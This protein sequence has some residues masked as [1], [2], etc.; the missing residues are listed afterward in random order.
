MNLMCFFYGSFRFGKTRGISSHF[1]ELLRADLDDIKTAGGS[2][3]GA[4]AALTSSK[5]ARKIC[6]KL[7]MLLGEHAHVIRVAL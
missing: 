3:S 4:S 7:L 6:G 1:P 5:S 2:E